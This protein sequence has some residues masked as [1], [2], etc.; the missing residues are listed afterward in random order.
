MRFLRCSVSVP[1]SPSSVA[2]VMT[3]ADEPED[4]V[5]ALETEKVSLA[6]HLQKLTVEVS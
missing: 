6:I 3:D 1:L 4:A 2:R 5:D